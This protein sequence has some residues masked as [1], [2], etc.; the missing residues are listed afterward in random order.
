M[1]HLLERRLTFKPSFDDHG[2]LADIPHERI[3]FGG[4]FG[5]QLDGAFVNN[6]SESVVLFTHGNRHNITK[7]REHYRLFAALGQSF[8]TFDYPGYGR[9]PGTPSEKSVY[10][11]ARAAYAHITNNRGYSPKKIIAYGCSM[12]GA[13]AIELAQHVPVAGLITESTFTNTWDMAKHLYPFLPLWRLLPKR[14]ENDRKVPHIKVPMLIIHGEKDP[15]VPVSMASQLA[16]GAIHPA[17]TIVIPDANHINSLELGAADLQ[18]AIED[19]IATT[20]R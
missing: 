9:S 13:V 15:I 18:G 8:F 16:R 2:G 1:L 14:F 12:G 11:S 19:F 17:R 5:M 4:E 10:A 6:G 7:F 3:E 20:V